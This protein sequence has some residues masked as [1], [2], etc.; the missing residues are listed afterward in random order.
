M[1]L[2]FLFFFLFFTLNVVDDYRKWSNINWLII[3]PLLTNMS[4][5]FLDKMKSFSPKGHCILWTKLKIST[6]LIISQI[7]LWIKN[8]IVQKTCE[9][10]LAGSIHPT[11]DP[12]IPCLAHMKQTLQT[13]S[14]WSLDIEFCDISCFTLRNAF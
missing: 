12:Y 7:L 14:Y 4:W 5:C 11:R 1:F 3:F 10:S 2:F 6:K 9:G 13:C 8:L